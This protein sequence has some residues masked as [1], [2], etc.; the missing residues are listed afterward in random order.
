MHITTP[1]IGVDKATVAEI[2][3][4]V[5]DSIAVDDS[6]VLLESDKASVEVPS[7]SAGVVK[8][9][10]VNQGDEVAEGAV[11]IELEAEEG[12]S[13]AVEPQ[14]AD[15]PQKTS[16]NTPTSLSDQDI[17]AEVS[18]HQPAASQNQTA[19]AGS[20]ATVEVKVPDIDVEKA[21]VGEILVQVGDQI[22][23]DQSIVVVESDKAT[24][25][26]PSTV[27]GTVASIEI[28][29]GDSVKE[30]VLILTVTTAEAAP[31]AEQSQAQAEQQH[32]AQAAPEAKA[33]PAAP[34]SAA[35]AGDV[36][37]KVPDLGVDK[38]AVA[39]ILVQVGDTVEKDQ[40]IIVVESDKATVEVPSTAAGLIKAIH[41]ELGQ[42]VSE[43]IA[44]VTIEAE[45]QAAP[46]PQAAAKAEAPAQKAAP[47]APTAPASSAVPSTHTAD[48]LTK[49]QN[50]ANSKVY[51]GPAV[52]KLARELGVIL[53]DVK[54]SGPHARVMKEDLVAYVK[55]RLTAPQTAPAAAAV[56]AAPSG[57]PKLPSFDAF[58]GV[59]EKALTR[60]QQVSIP[61]LSLNNYIPQVTQFDAADKP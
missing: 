9:I 36:E 54:A 1:D 49:E 59:E 37:V 50:A 17:I 35:P 21:L 39:E 10:L 30:G 14:L 58:G 23:V 45:G 15:A 40:S 56:A 24:V 28:Q 8:S 55:S 12:T 5:G 51:A 43:G 42:N 22:D 25:E 57:L 34:A 60:L 33:E 27:S 47:A 44:L 46:A 7:T 16:E 26:V 3:V 19:A 32:A 48:K 11:L 31:A 18:S 61:Q 52:R 53:A 29:A 20:A 4:K 6:I 41:V 2:L 38:A 13:Q